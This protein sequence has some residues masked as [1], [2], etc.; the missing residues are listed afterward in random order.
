MGKIRVLVIDDSAVVRTLLTEVL[1]SDPGIEVIG[2]AAD[3]LIA[4][5]KIKRLEPDVLTLDVE[6]PKMD[7]ITF[8]RNLMRL[9]PMP[10][11]MVSSLTEKGAE[12]T[13][14]ALE[15]G[16]VDF[17]TKPKIDIAAGL[18]A[19]GKEIIAKVKMAAKARVGAISERRA[20][21]P[22][23]KDREVE[24]KLDTDA[25]L[26]RVAPPKHFR[27]TDTLIAIGASTGGTEAI[28]DVLMQLP[29]DAPGIVIVQH[30]PG[31]FS[32]AF[33]KRMDSVSRMRVIEA[34][35]GREIRQGHVLIA[36]GTHH[37]MVRRSGARF[38]CQ[39][40]DGPP[41]NRH[42]PSVDVLFRSVAQNL[43]PNAIGAI[44]T[45]MGEDGAK[46]LLEMQEAGAFTVAQDKESSLVWGMP[47]VAVKLGA[48]QQIVPLEQVAATLLRAVK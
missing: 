18:A 4:R 25:V 10:V 40:D 31:A 9:H 26:A 32:G 11:L 1:D 35:D 5:E 29:A 13:L 3:P 14:E 2:T 19:D 34:E 41:V 38:V 7:G 21:R 12:V 48:A 30:I 33:A 20:R 37:M 42:K 44:L 16:A 23:A 27:T 28:K 15:L 47:G 46:G 45:G 36:P 22:V 43:G 39:L 24:P 8:L 6:M 17:V